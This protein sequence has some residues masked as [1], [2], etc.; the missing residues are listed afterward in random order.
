[1]LE[2]K[3][4]WLVLATMPGSYFSSSW[5]QTSFHSS[6]GTWYVKS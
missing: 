6:A 4:L 5:L 1:M 2:I 3:A